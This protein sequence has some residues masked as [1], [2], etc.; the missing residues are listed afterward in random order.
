MSTIWNG[1]LSAEQN[2]ARSGLDRCNSYMATATIC[3][4]RTGIQKSTKQWN[5][6]QNM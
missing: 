4:F 3:H 1:Q 2:T 6:V 5:V